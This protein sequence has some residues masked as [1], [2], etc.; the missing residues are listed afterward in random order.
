M[1]TIK[2]YTYDIKILD[3]NNNEIEPSEEIKIIFTNN[4]INNKNLD[5]NIYHTSTDKNNS[6]TTE[7]LKGE[8]EGETITAKTDSFSYYT[9]EF[10]Y[11]NLTYSIE[12]NSEVKLSTILEQVGLEGEVESVIGSNDNL[13]SFENKNNEW[14]VKANQAFKTTEWMKVTIDDIVYEITVTDATNYTITYQSGS[15]GQFADGTTTNVV[16]YSLTTDIAIEYSHTPN[17]DD[18]GLQNGNYANNLNTNDVVTI[19]GSPTLTVDIYYNGESVSWDWLSV[20][21]GN[22]P[23]YTAS[24]NRTSTG[25]VTTDMGAPNNNNKFG[26]SQSGSY[27]VNGNFLTNMGHTTLTI[28]GDSVTFGFKSDSSGYGKGYGYYA[29]VSGTCEIKT[30]TSGTYKEP[31]ANNSDYLFKEWSQDPDTISTS[32]TIT[33]TYMEDL[34]DENSKGTYDG[35]DWKI[36]HDGTLVIGKSGVIQTFTNRSS[37]TNDSWP[38]YQYRNQITSISF[39]GTVNG[40][41]SHY[42]MFR[43]CENVTNVVNANNFN[44]SNVT[45]MRYMF[46]NCSGLTSLNVSGFDTSNVTDMSDMFYGCSSLTSLNVSGFDTSNVTD[47][48][49]MFYGCSSLTSLDVNSFNTSNVTNMSFMFD[50]CSS[51]TSLDVSNFNTNNV[52]NMTYMFNSCS[53]LTSLDISNFNTNNVTDMSY[54]FSNCSGLTSL[55][56]SGFNTSNATNMTYMFNSCSSLTSLDVSN[57]NTNNVT[58]MGCMFRECS[59]LTSLDLSNFNT[60]NV[61]NM[62]YMFRECSSLTS[63]DVSSFNTSNVTNMSYMFSTCRGL[64]SLDLSNFT[65]NNVTDMSHMFSSCRSLTSLNLSNF[66]T[67]NVTNM[68]LMFNSCGNLTN[69]DLNSFNTS[70]VTNMINMFSDCSSL[71][72]LDLSNFNTA[73]VT[74][75][76]YMFYDCNSLTSLDISSFDTSNLN[77]MTNM[78]GNMI[79]LD[80]LKL[81]TNWEFLSKNGVTK[82]WRRDGD[83]IVYTAEEL[84]NF[85]DGATMAGTYRA[86]PEAYAEFDSSTGQLRIFRDADETYTNEQVIGT[87]TY[88][89]DIETITGESLPKWNANKSNITSVVIEDYFRPQTAYAM[90]NS[91]SNLTTI[92]GIE[93]LCTTDIE[94][95]KVMFYGCSSLTSLD[96]SSFNTGN[97]ISMENM[98]KSCSGLTN[99]DLS[100]FNTSKVTDMSYMFNECNSLISLDLSS[101]NTSKVIDMQGMFWGCNNLTSLDLSSFNTS[102]VTN[103]PVMFMNCSSLTTLNLNSFNTSKVSHMEEMFDGCSSLTSLN[104]DNWNLSSITDITNIGGMFSDTASLNLS[105]KNWVIPV[106][107]NNVFDR[108]CDGSNIKK[109]DVTGW[110]LSATK[111]LYGLFGD[112]QKLEQIIG[113]ETWDTSNIENMSGMFQNCK[114]LKNLDVSNFDTS[115]VTDMGVMFHIC[116]SLTYLD[117]SSFDT[118]NVT[119]MGYI[120]SGTI[121]LNTLIL[122][123]DWNFLSGNDLT[124][125]WIRDGDT[126]MYTASELTSSYDGSTMSGTYR[127]FVSLTISE[128]VKGSLADIN[129]DFDFTINVLKD[130]VGINST[131]AYTGS[132]TGNLVFSNGNATFSLKHN[133]SISTYLPV[134]NTYTIT[135]NSDG[136]TLSKS[137]YTGTLTTDTISTFTDTLEGT[138]PTGI[139]IDLIPYILL[140]TF[141]ILGIFLIRK[142]KYI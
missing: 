27:T 140:I 52:T 26:G 40:N 36:K 42:G 69:L 61:T 132:K 28:P 119:N 47:M 51:L 72:S 55:N 9:V 17:V 18:T 7:V 95:M 19:P 62:S 32:T 22:Y 114:N 38:W 139:F 75:M 81:G 79:N 128:T 138:T 65:T 54:M 99:L 3:E 77:N 71:T 107:F 16:D 13:F 24:S 64:T 129:K 120:F 1:N 122:G 29:I 60:N 59:G 86:L 74:N 116:N 4:L 49:D 67:S 110:D 134:G 94:N 130:Y 30:I 137:N 73:N 82:K 21:A 117:L 35:I 70:S 88:Y 103:M 133:E 5:T 46:S 127:A 96:V 50:D 89:T 105:T 83:T 141:G 136:Y 41:G 8:V 87:K 57:F 20:W 45:N 90:F 11:N 98:F 23:S 101:F 15:D 123:P 121:N 48:S 109:I 102:K 12:G 111:S 80:T 6:L 56:V 135:Q 58:N 142:F 33:A 53:S 106:N 44:T 131:Y 118:S 34:L 10:T 104:L 92:T 37:R 108:T 97:V 124:K 25:Y 93:N 78:F 126:T 91:C 14:Y 2:S 76:G 112:A 115:N 31:V 68:E 84:T 100:G 63:L 113:L 125:S 43:S 85:Y 39:V 66:N